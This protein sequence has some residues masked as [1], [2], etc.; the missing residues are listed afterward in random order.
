M[1][2]LTHDGR[3]F[4]TKRGYFIN[5]YIYIYIYIYIY[6]FLDPLS[7]RVRLNVEFVMTRAKLQ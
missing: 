2:V 7:V 1:P 4:L 5:T 6:T 3:V